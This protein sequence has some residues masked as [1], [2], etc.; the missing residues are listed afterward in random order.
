M[1]N[2]EEALPWS[3]KN[4][5]K[6][7]KEALVHHYEGD[8]LCEECGLPGCNRS[9]EEDI[10]YDC[11]RLSESEAREVIESWIDEQEEGYM[12]ADNFV[13]APISRPIDLAFAALKL[14]S[15]CCGKE[16]FVKET[17]EGTYFFGFRYGH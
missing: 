3:A 4:S 11:S 14:K 8:A 10:D 16:Q 6:R 7:L 9:R 5:L 13:H 2:A 1:Q 17:D 15:G 12:Y